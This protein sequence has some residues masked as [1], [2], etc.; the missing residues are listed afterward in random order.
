MQKKYFVNYVRICDLQS[1]K[2]Q[3]SIDEVCML[4]ELYK[5][6]RKYKVKVK[7]APRGMPTQY[8]NHGGHFDILK[9]RSYHNVRNYFIYRFIVQN[10]T[11]LSF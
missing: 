3:K 4:N 7:P 2:Y 11:V 8:A 6:I 1:I 5:V 10:F 9:G